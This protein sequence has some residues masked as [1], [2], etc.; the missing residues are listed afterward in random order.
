MT[1]HAVRRRLIHRQGRSWSYLWDAPAPPDTIFIAKSLKLHITLQRIVPIEERCKRLKGCILVLIK[2]GEILHQPLK[3]RRID[4]EHIGISVKPEATVRHQADRE[5]RYLT[6]RQV[7]LLMG[8]DFS[9][10]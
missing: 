9:F 4:S 8:P 5:A 3:T 10:S 7:K 1:A 2:Q 6:D